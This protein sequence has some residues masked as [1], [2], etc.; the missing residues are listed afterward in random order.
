[1]LSDARIQKAISM[2]KDFVFDQAAIEA[3]AKSAKR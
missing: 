3:L 2:N 1:M